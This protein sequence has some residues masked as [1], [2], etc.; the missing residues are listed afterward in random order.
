M[1]D[2]R[3]F[4]SFFIDHRI[5]EAFAYLSKWRDHSYGMA[6]FILGRCCKFGFHFDHVPF[7]WLIEY[8]YYQRSHEQG[9][10]LPKA[11]NLIPQLEYD[12]HKY[13]TWKRPEDGKPDY[14]AMGLYRRN[15]EGHLTYIRDAWKIYGSLFALQYLFYHT[16]CEQSC[17]DFR[18]QLVDAGYFFILSQRDPIDNLWLSTWCQRVL[19]K[20]SVVLNVPDDLSNDHKLECIWILLSHRCVIDA[21]VLLIVRWWCF[22]TENILLK[23]NIGRY[24]FIANRVEGL[25]YN[26]CQD[27]MRTRVIVAM[28]CLQKRFGVRDMTRLLG[29]TAW[30]IRH[31]QHE[32][33]ESIF[34][35]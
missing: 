30:I 17:K 35:K 2:E 33:I 22:N 13:R 1:W 32:A 21:R 23:Y 29:Q 34:T 18:K 27:E 11:M 25:E 8:E 4:F 31:D 12:D 3:V 16:E 20:Q 9:C 5:Q 26:H 7:D 28:D 15:L 24:L 6:D 10:N 19:Y 14:L